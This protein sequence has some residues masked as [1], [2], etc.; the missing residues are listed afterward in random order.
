MFVVFI[1]SNLVEEMI[2]DTVS[3]SELRSTDKDPVL[4]DDE[5]EIFNTSKTPKK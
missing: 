4:T 3:L 2:N 1:V 5:G